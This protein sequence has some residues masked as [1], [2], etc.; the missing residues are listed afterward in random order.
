MQVL[1]GEERSTTSE[2][3]MNFPVGSLP[4]TINSF[5]TEAKGTIKYAVVTCLNY[6]LRVHFPSSQMSVT[7]IGPS[8]QAFGEV[9]GRIADMSTQEI[10]E[11]SCWR[12]FFILQ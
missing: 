12:L 6:C 5:V 2:E 4:P 10:Q 3:A 1:L 9:A 11:V 8:N 7:I